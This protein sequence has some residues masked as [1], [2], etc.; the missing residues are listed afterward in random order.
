MGKH[1]NK[2]QPPYYVYW[3]RAAKN[4]HYIGA[5]TRPVKRL[6]QHNGEMKGG[7]M[8][9]N[10]KGPWRFHCIISGFRTW[11]EAL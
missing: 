2:K 11:K 6:K 10:N 5:T 4:L 1:Y 3:I 9:T 8:R 7:A